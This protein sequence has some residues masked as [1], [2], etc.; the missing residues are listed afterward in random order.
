MKKHIIILS[1][2]LIGVA[3]CGCTADDINTTV[4]KLGDK[5]G[6]EV[7]LNLKEEDINK[8]KGNANKVKDTVTDIT[9]DEEVREAAGNLIDAIEGAVKDE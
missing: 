7:E 2:M 4:N 9:E 1:V 8:I 3:L 6:V 5:A